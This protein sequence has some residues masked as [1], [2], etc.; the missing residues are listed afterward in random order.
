MSISSSVSFPVIVSVAVV[1]S[2]FI[3]LCIYLRL[4][5]KKGGENSVNT[6]SQIYVGNLSYRV[7]ESHLREY[8]SSFGE[9]ESLNVIK[10]HNTGRSRGFGFITFS[11]SDHAESALEYNGNEFE[12]RSLVVRIAKP[13]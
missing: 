1:A 5:N 8:F 6:N 12:G 7:S 4:K 3:L 11:S 10:N 13:K 9:I 2:C